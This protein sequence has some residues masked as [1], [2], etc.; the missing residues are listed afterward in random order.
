MVAILP[1]IGKKNVLH[2]ACSDF[3]EFYPSF[4]GKVKLWFSLQMA[5]AALPKLKHL[6][7]WFYPGIDA[8]NRNRFQKFWH[9][10]D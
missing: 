7:A 9:Q 5:P 8:A 4:Y 3:S 6:I 2:I 10:N 1:K